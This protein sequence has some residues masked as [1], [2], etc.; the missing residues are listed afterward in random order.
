MNSGVTK[1]VVAFLL[2]AAL[3]AWIFWPRSIEPAQESNRFKTPA[4]YSI[5]VPRDWGWKIDARPL[6][7]TA[8]DKLFLSPRNPGYRPPGM[9]IVR[10][11]REPNETDLKNN[12]GFVNKSF[13]DEPALVFHGSRKK[14]WAWEAVFQRGGD[15][16]R[17]TLSIPGYE[18]IPS[19]NWFGYV[20]SFRYEP[21]PATQPAASGL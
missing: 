11:A 2:V 14:Y 12:D 15:W 9:S 17:L 19:S 1:V 7:R 18:D 8:K 3:C 4:G 6:D 10:L 5:I 16:F 13:Q 20:N 21:P